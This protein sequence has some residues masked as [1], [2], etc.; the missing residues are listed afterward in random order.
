MVSGSVKV[1]GWRFPLGNTTPALMLSEIMVRLAQEEE[2]FF[3][4]FFGCNVV[5]LKL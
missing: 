4:F 5:F 1:K 3:V 2:R